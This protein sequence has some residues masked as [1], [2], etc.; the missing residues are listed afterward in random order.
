MRICTLQL[1]LLNDFIGIITNNIGI[2]GIIEVVLLLMIVKQFAD[3]IE[4]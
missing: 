2:I 3:Y 4:N 1:Y